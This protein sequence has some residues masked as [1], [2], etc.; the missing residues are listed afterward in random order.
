MRASRRRPSPSAI[1]LVGLS[2]LWMALAFAAGVVPVRAGAGH[3]VEIVDFGY[4]PAD[5]TISPG[6]TV[7]WTNLD[8]VAHTATANDG[9]WDTGLLE[10]GA[11]ASITFTA[12]GTYEYLCT[13]HPS[14]TGR[15]T[16]VAA[17]TQPTP[18]PAPGGGSLPDV[19]MSGSTVSPIAVLG[20]LLLGLAGL[21]A[22]ARRDRVARER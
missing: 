15:I 7:T 14:M 18:S 6:D 22:L 20:L 3:V 12:P 1:L 10:Q 19:A 8:A 11:S 16:V 9:A 5:L 21:A 2:L 13:P 17:A 4:A